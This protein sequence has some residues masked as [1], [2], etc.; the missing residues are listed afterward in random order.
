MPRVLRLSPAALRDLDAARMWLHQPG[1]GPQA[2]DRFIKIRAS[3]QDLAKVPCRWPRFPRGRNARRLIS[4]RYA[5][6]YVVEPDTG[7]NDTAGDVMILRVYGPF[8]EY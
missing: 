6:I 2:W 8:Q 5:I 3:I 1:S 4:G 7:D